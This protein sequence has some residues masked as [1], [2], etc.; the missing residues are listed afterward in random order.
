MS[1]K[2]EKLM[3]EKKRKIAYI[4]INNPNKK[5]AIELPMIHKFLEYLD[6]VENNPR[7]RCLVIKSS[8]N[9]V[10]SAGWDLAIFEPGKTE[11]IKTLLNDGARISK[12]IHLLKKPVITQI[13]GSAVGTGTIIAL[14][15]DF[16]IVANKKDLFFQLPE[17]IIGPGIFPATGPTVGAVKILGHTRVMDMLL[18]G[19]RV[20]LEEFNSWGAIS[21]IIDP[22][23]DLESAVESFANDLSKRPAELLILTKNAI[24]RMSMRLLNEFYNL[25][26]EMGRYYFDGLEGKKRQEINQFLEKLDKKYSTVT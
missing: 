11:N 2:D 10:F 20:V 1:L 23:E 5:N 21:R 12:K 9:D 25:E 22:A 18:T 15:S 24:N 7:I 6:E 13:Q 19:R 4:T 8:G 17:L 3:F 26:N 14:A 16:R